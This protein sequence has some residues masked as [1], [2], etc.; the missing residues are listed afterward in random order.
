MYDTVVKIKA[1]KGKV[2]KNRIHKALEGGW[3]LGQAHRHNIP[4][5]AAQGR[6][7]SSEWDM[8]RVH[9]DLVVS[10]TE[11]N[12]T[13]PLGRS[14]SGSGMEAICNTPKAV[15][16]GFCSGERIAILDSNR[17]NPAIINDQSVFD[18]RLLDKKGGRRK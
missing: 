14:M 3:A 11:V 5:I 9:S 15:E 10:P 4:H 8:R 18:I 13:E 1:D 7:K 6:L 17:I 12:L 2:A 16:D